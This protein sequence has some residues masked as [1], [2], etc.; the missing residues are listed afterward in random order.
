MQTKS[1]CF[2]FSDLASLCSAAVQVPAAA[3]NP[4]LNPAAAVAAA[5]AAAQAASVTSQA[6]AVTAAGGKARS[7]MSLPLISGR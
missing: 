3:P 4:A 2:N 6:S 1:T 5:Q 7:S